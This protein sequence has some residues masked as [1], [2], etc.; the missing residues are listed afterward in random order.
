MSNRETSEKT[1]ILFVR[2]ADVHN[3]NDVIYGRL[4]RFRI[5]TLGEQQAARLASYLSREPLAAIYTS[6]QLRARQTAR[7][8]SAYHPEVPVSVSS[9]LAEVKTGWQGTPNSK[10]GP[11]PDFYAD[12][13]LHDD[14]TTEQIADR[15]RRFVRRVVRR[16]QGKTVVAVSHG[17]PIVIVR[18]L[19]L[20][21]EV[22]FASMREG[23]Y[24]AKTSVVR[25]TLDSTEMPCEVAYISPEQQLAATTV[26]AAG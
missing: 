1:T 2:H 3:P 26:V 17:D 20:G 18:L 24:P 4:P 13:K 23:I 5:S 15:L 12:R 8:V 9:L 6:P 16:H 22:S 10:A 7:Y 21:R 19:A 11:N 25:L 14:E